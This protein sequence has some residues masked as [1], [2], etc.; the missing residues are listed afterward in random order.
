MYFFKLKK[1]FNFYKDTYSHYILLI[2]PKQ[3]N[4]RIY[5]LILPTLITK[6]EAI[7]NAGQL[8]S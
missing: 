2:I 6:Q 1:T 3:L 7:E 5:L 4:L 8:T